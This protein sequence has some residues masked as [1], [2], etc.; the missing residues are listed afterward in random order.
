MML[1][2]YHDKEK[3]E[4]QPKQVETKPKKSKKKSEDAE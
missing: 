2:R 3:A 1:R 4:Q